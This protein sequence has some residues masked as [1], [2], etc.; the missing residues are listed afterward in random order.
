MEFFVTKQE[1][2]LFRALE[3]LLTNCIDN[4]GMPKRPT[5]KQ[6]HKASKALT[7]YENYAREKRAKNEQ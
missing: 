2:K 6:L 5:A 7:D 4:V 1:E 3:K